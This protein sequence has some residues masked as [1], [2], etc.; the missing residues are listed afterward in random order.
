[1]TGYGDDKTMV[2]NIEISG[3]LNW[4]VVEALSFAHYTNL[5]FSVLVPLIKSRP[6][7]LAIEKDGIVKLVNV[8]VAGL[9]SKIEPNSWS[10]SVA[11]G[12]NDSI[13]RSEKNRDNYVRN[14]ITKKSK[15]DIF[16]VWLPHQ[17]RFV[18][19]PVIFLTGVKA[20]A[21]AYQ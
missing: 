5:G 1:M 11:S 2:E 6:Y 15:I 21:S 20:K 14:V 17:E 10:I 12:A 18:E 4:E 3:E 7:D 16:L 13:Y 9:K 8:K 19:L